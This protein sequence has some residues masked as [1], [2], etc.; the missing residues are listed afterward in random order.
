MN[1]P[2]VNMKLLLIFVL[3]I[4][5]FVTPNNC[6]IL[7]SYHVHV[8]N[9]LSPGKVLFVHCKSSD[10]DLGGHNLGDGQEFSW[11]FYMNFIKTTLFWCRMA[12]DDQSFADLSVLDSNS[13]FYKCG[14]EQE[15]IWI[16][17][18]D[19]VYLRNIPMNVDEFQRSWGTIRHNG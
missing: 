18:D 16:A 5:F 9:E 15:C 10:N 19:G 4:S 14:H 11:S 7:N 17:K 12:P 8:V 3:A 6:N 13:L 2:S 1:S